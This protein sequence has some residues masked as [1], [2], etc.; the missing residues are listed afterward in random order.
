MDD[1]ACT[2]RILSADGATIRV[3]VDGEVDVEDAIWLQPAL[4]AL[5]SPHVALIVDASN[6][7]FFGPSAVSA[8]LA[9]RRAALKAGGT[10]TLERVPTHVRRVIAITGAEI[11]LGDNDA[12]DDTLPT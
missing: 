1:S 3:A 4:I 10:F 2:I 9:T 8:L 5:I 6:I 12:Q 11:L 7:G